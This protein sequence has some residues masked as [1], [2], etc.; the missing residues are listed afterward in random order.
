MNRQ[1]LLA[2]ALATSLALTACGGDDDDAPTEPVDTA[3]EPA[4][5]T[6]DPSD[7]AGD[8]AATDTAADT[9]DG[10]AA[11]DADA[12]GDGPVSTLSPEVPAEF[13]PAVAAMDVSG[14]NLARLE[15]DDIDDDPTLGTPAPTIVG[16]DFD[17]NPVT[18]DAAADGPTMVVFL[19]H[20]CPHCNAEIPVLNEL[21]DAGRFPD[22]LNIVAISTAPN[23]ERPNWPPAEWLDE[24]N[25]TWPAIADGVDVEAGVFTGAEAFGVSGFPFVVLLDDNGDIAARWSGE[26]DPDEII[27]TIE[28]RLGL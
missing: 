27:E 25:W 1:R 13:V 24:M 4:E 11:D 10:A 15:T 16:L 14:E 17:G 18:I 12:S 26:R 19:A 7:D 22:D 3:T 28:S 6:A 23:P 20:W 2:A 8:D 21:R 5:S 9:T